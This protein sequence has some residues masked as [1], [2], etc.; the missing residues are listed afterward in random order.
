M[1]GDRENMFILK[2]SHEIQRAALKGFLL[3]ALLLAFGQRADGHSID[4]VL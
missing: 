4:D 1:S 3:L 2:F